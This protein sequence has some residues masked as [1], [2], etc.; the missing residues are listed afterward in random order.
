MSVTKKCRQGGV[1]SLLLKT[2]LAFAQQYGY[3]EVFLTTGAYQDQYRLH[4]CSIY[5]F[6]L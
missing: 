4:L 5:E 3:D 6:V 1:G 2:L